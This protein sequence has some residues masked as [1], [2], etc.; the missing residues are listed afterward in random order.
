MYVGM[1]VIGAFSCLKNVFKIR[2][3]SNIIIFYFGQFLIDNQHHHRLF[4]RINY[5]SIPIYY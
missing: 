4:V 5:K 2:L 1:D 3:I